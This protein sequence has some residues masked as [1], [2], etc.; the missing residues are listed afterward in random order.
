LRAPE[1][2]L[3]DLISPL[4]RALPAEIEMSPILLRNL[5]KPLLANIKSTNSGIRCGALSTFETIVSRCH[6][7]A[8]LEQV[9]DEVL[10]PLKASKVPAAD[11]RVLH[12]Q[13]LVAIPGS[14]TLA[15][16]IPAGLA[17]VVGKEPNE[18]AIAAE[19]KAMTS[20]LGSGLT[21]G[22]GVDKSVLDAFIKGLA[23]K[24]PSVR[25]TWVLRVGELYWNLSGEDLRGRETLLFAEEIMDMLLEVWD[26]VVG[27]PLRSAQTGL[28]TAGYVVA[29]ICLCRLGSA[30]S[31]KL[32]AA[33]KR[34]EISKK[35]IVFQPKPSFL[36]N[37]RIYSKLT[38]DEE[39]I[40]AIRT[41][42]AV[43]TDLTQEQSSS[44]T[45][46]AWAVAFLFFICAANVK[47]H[48]KKEAVSALAVAYAR[49]PATIGKT[50]ANGMWQ[51]W[52]FVE[53]Q[54]KE[55]VAVAAKTGNSLLY[56]AVRS[57]CLP[58]QDADRLGGKVD[59]KILKDQLVGMIVLCR[60]ELLP[61][62]SWIETCQRSGID[63]G[64]LVR[65][66]A[67]KLLFKINVISQ[68]SGRVRIL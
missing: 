55:H 40:W 6:D 12:A 16:K 7:D 24:R 4:V 27:S 37:H 2:V 45:G 61:R 20:H 13:M 29:S 32:T 14:I 63:P 64:A 68:L 41:L 8:L 9:A 1:V 5:L 49:N 35:A 22:V 18:V 57:I 59:E 54:Y 60:P 30:G 19:L 50:I 15:R 17:T 67:S 51:W 11:Q 62:V 47:P 21:G 42:T 53:L 3:N 66:E 43:S 36:L 39:H 33:I 52:R 10:G 48:V 26:E 23:D 38:S 25:T 46:D 56:R 58:P 34:A 65:E 44:E 31:V 28:V